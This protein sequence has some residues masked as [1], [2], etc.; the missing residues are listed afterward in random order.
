MKNL[1]AGS[2]KQGGSTITQ[3]VVKNL[4]LSSEQKIIRKL[5]EAI[6]SYRIEQRLTKDEIFE[7]LFKSN[8]FWRRGL[9]E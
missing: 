8:L 2:V 1:Q 9:M 3:Q 5:K 7:N 4:L 6:L